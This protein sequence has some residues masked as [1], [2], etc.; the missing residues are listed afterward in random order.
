M[1]ITHIIHTIYIIYIFVKVTIIIFLFNLLLNYSK[2][3]N[4]IN[5]YI[6]DIIININNKFPSIITS[7]IN[8]NNI[9]KYFECNFKKSFYV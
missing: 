7:L 5:E 3:H 8:I 6:S 9:L 2:I 1:K 4:D